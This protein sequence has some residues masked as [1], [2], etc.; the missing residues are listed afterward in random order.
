[1]RQEPKDFLDTLF[2]AAVGATDPLS[3]LAD[4]LPSPPK[5]KT[6]V[7]GA[8]K[9]AAA[10]AKA[11]EDHWDGPLEGLVITRYEHGLPLEKIRVVEAGHPV[12]DAEGAKA[13]DDILALLDGLSEDDLM[14]CLISGGG[15]RRK[16]RSPRRCWPPAPISPK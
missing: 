3:T 12:P 14:L 8:G 9:A 5:G 7:I 4:H 2:K 13:A 1:M 10:M 15:W 6:I 16:R 11:V